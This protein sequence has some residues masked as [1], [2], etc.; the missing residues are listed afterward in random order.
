MLFRQSLPQ[1]VGVFFDLLRIG[2]RKNEALAL[3]PSD[4]SPMS[5]SINKAFGRDCPKV[6]R[7]IQL[8]AYL[9]EKLKTLCM[10]K[11]IDEAIFSELNPNYELLKYQQMLGL[12]PIRIHSVR[13]F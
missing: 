12:P 2:V 8:P 6:Y 4:V 9:V 5:I 13:D 10:G 11:A 7:T 3:T 1:K